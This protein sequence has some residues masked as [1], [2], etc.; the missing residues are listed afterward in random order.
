MYTIQTRRDIYTQDTTIRDNTFSGWM[1]QNIG[2]ADAEVLGF[3]LKPGEK[4]DFKDIARP[5]VLWTSQIFIK[6]A[7]TKVVLVRI[8]Y[9]ERKED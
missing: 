9:S 4:L 7:G 3:V 2:A 8:Q 5:D 6:C 1:A